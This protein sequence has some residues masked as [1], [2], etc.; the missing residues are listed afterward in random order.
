MR[1]RRQT[2]PLPSVS[3]T[4]CLGRGRRQEAEVEEQNPVEVGPN[5]ES[6]APAG[7]LQEDGAMGEP[8]QGGACTALR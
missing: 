1:Q 7:P 6:F 8:S 2:E 4:D 3:G 5:Y